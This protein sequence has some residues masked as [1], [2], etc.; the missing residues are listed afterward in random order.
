[1]QATTQNLK[2]LAYHWKFLTESEKDTVMETLSMNEK[3]EFMKVCAEVINKG[4]D[5][6]QSKREYETCGQT[7]D[8]YTG[9]EVE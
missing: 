1:M 4:L 8:Y 9:T 5:D 3:L 6:L 7:D 2:S